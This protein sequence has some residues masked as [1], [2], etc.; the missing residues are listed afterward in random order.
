MNRHAAANAKTLT[1]IPKMS[2]LA[3]GCAIYF[4]K[5]RRLSI[6][7]YHAGGERATERTANEKW[8]QDTHSVAMLKVTKPRYHE[9]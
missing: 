6:D 9:G 7:I 5:L 3:I 8:R 4:L 2:I 1:F